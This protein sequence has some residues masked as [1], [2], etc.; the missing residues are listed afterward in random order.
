MM[1]PLQCEV[2]FAWLVLDHSN[3]SLGSQLSY[4]PKSFSFP[5]VSQKILE[6]MQYQFIENVDLH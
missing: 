4:F 3:I 1:R 6:I 5:E 2:V